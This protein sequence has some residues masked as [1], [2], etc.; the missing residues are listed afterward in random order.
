VIEKNERPDH[1]PLCGRQDAADLES[2]EITASLLDDK[3][4]HRH[5]RNLRMR[6]VRGFNGRRNVLLLPSRYSTAVEA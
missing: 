5:S 2:A 4:D 6:I 1:A 3:I